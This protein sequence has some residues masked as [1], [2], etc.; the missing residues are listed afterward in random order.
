MA[1]LSNGR[2]F[3]SIGGPAMRA[4]VALVAVAAVGC[5]LMPPKPVPRSRTASQGAQLDEISRP[6]DVIIDGKILLGSQSLTAGIT[7]SGPLTLAD[8]ETWLADARNHEPLE[9]VLPLG[10][11][12]M[13]G[14]TKIPPDNPL[15]RAKIELGRQ[16]FVDMRLSGPDRNHACFHCHMPGRAYSGVDLAGDPAAGVPMRIAPSILNRIFSESQFWDGRRATLEEQ[17]TDPIFS[18]YEMNNSPAG[19]L[20]LLNSAPAYRRQFE[21]IFGEVSVENAARALACFVRALVGAEAPFDFWMELKAWEGRDQ[22]TLS[23]AERRFADKVRTFAREVPFS[24]TARKG[25]AL[26]VGKA[27]CQACHS[28][29]NFTDEKFHNVGAGWDDPLS[30]EGRQRVTGRVEDRGA[31]KTPTLRNLRNSRR[32]MHADQLETLEDVVD[33]LSNGGTPNPHLDPLV[34]P[35]NLSPAEK[36]Q[37]LAFLEALNGRTPALALGRL[38]ETVD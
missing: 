13:A 33:W 4:L 14:D 29:A 23:E 16:L 7:G 28:G 25:H 18:P 6:P 8:V 17:V 24:P 32:Y 26:F 11:R 15:T 5:D 20:A 30:D 31:F 9:F 19:L 10:L 38:P 36:R 21:V 12:S 2:C 34:R 37:L 3:V 27:G 35:L 22:A 1:A